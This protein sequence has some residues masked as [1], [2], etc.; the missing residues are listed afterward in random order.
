MKIVR[1]SLKEAASLRGLLIAAGLLGLLQALLP[2]SLRIRC[3]F[4]LWS[5][6]PCPTCGASRC[7]DRMLHGAWAEA[8]FIQP[9]VF[10]ATLGF[11]LLLLY[12]IVAGWSG[13]PVPAIQFE[14]RRERIAAVLLVILLVAANWV[15]LLVS[16][17]G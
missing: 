9:L 5:G 3:L 11:G 2:D 17:T 4:R 16:T 14:N 6:H 8:F 15:Y 1:A 10:T 12:M 7:L 13:R